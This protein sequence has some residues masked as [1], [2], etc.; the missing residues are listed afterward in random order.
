MICS[1]VNC[2][3]HSSDVVGTES[4]PLDDRMPGSSPCKAAEP[5]TSQQAS[6]AK[7]AVCC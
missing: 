6:E 3:G 2:S 1:H 7:L 5:I 4:Q